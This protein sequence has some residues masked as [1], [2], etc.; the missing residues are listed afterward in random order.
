MEIKGK[1]VVVTG[2]AGFIG[3]H[4]VD[5]LIKEKPESISVLS[6]FFLGNKNNLKEAEKNFP[7]L[8]IVDID[9]TRYA[10][11]KEFLQ[12]S[13]TDI[14][15]NLAVIPLPTSL[16]KP[17]WSFN[18]NIKMASNMCELLRKDMFST[19]VQFSS[20]EV[21]GTAVHI[22]MSEEHP[23]NPETPYGA[24]KAATDL[25]AQSYHRTFNLDIAI[26]RPFN[27]YGPRQNMEKYAGVIPLT[28]KRILNNENIII[29]GDGNQTRDFIYVEDTV[30]AVIKL[31]KSKVRGI[32]INISTG[33]EITINRIITE[34]A[35][36]LNY[37]RQFTYK[38]PR[39]G[40]VKRHLGDNSKLKKLLEF[41]PKISIE[42]GIKKTTDWYKSNITP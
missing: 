31:A 9:I 29:F 28:I 36:N 15:F 2:G 24:S 21:Y 35:K 1:S 10:E 34:I 33:K 5:A 25:L 3:S 18:K 12:N 23:L 11:L 4:L 40:D 16:E 37:T 13:N 19:L 30:N 17:R 20:S 41:S 22:P 42:D 39:L 38:E 7:D 32:P 6:N 8:R 14:V 27:N 26:P